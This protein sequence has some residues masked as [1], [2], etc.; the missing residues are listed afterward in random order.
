VDRDVVVDDAPALAARLTSIVEDDARAVQREHGVF[1]IAVP[2]GSTARELLPG[3]AGAVVDWSRT[4]VFW[5]DERIV[6]ASHPQSNYG[7]AAS[8]WLW[9]AGVPAEQVH[10][11][12]TDDPDLARVAR[13]YASELE[14]VAGA[15]P[16]LDLVLLG[17]GPDGHVASL[18]PGHD[19]LGASASAVA[20]VDSPKPPPERITL[21][22]PVLSGASRVVIAT[23][24][25]S[26]ADAV[27]EAIDNPNSILPVA[28]VARRAS[29]V[30]FLL[31]PAAAA[32]LR[33]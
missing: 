26:K 25:A 13:R 23:F 27:A 18:F 30:L 6:P 19:A 16:C 14:R 32:R 2:G 17:V 21:T 10:P 31:D 8:L 11:V 22:M 20:I 4:D 15:P 9:P 12:A 7:L 29:R 28:T 1:T 3:L 5:V 33:S 24:G